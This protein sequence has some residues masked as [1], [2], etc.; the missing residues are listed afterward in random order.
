[1]VFGTRRNFKRFICKN[2]VIMKPIITKYRSTIGSNFKLSP[3]LHK[4]SVAPNSN[5]KSVSDFL[6]KELD[7]TDLGVE[8][9]SIN[10]VSGS[11][12]FF[13]RTKA[14]QDHTYLPQISPESV[15]SIHPTSFKNYNLQEND[16]I[17]SKD[18]NIGEVVILDKDY[19]NYMLSGALYKLPIVEESKYYLLA[20]LKHSFFRDQLDEMVPKG[21][22]IRHAGT[23]FLVCKVPIPNKNEQEII[24][25]VE[26]MM[27]LVIKVEKEINAKFDFINHTIIAELKGNQKKESVFNF[28]QPAF[29]EIV[30]NKRLDTGIYSETFANIDFLIR[31]YAKGFYYIDETKLKSGNTPELRH[32]GADQNLKFR[33]VTPT[34]CSDIGY[35]LFDERISMLA[36]NNLNQNA[37]L[38]VN[39]TSKGGKGEYVGIA[40]YYDIDIYGKGHHNQGI[41]RVFDYTDEELIFMT[42]FMNTTIMRKYCS[43]MCVG[44]KMKELRANQFLLIPFPDFTE[45]IKQ[46][47]VQAYNNSNDLSKEQK[48]IFANPNK[49]LNTAGIVQLERLLRKLQLKLNDT[50]DKIVN[51]EE[52]FIDYTI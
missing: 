26:T 12:Y 34:N 2:Q 47:I 15:V 4:K 9:G 44:S 48:S 21:A 37:M 28:C 39:R 5:T 52:V 30:S 3:S 11:N 29:S 45:E 7:R 49:Y 42:C 31:N 13:V 22:T 36:G 17:L 23:K 33:W 50:L 43:C 6:Y 19:P 40:T 51:D 14:L 10:Y 18:S 32:I 27:K 20:F 35:L 8:V 38:L 16:V 41:Y 46:K 24:T 25:F 1:M